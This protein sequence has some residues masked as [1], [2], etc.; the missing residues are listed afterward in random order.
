VIER[1]ASGTDLTFSAANTQRI[2]RMGHSDMWM[3]F[4]TR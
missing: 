1:H 4:E 3:P 2:I